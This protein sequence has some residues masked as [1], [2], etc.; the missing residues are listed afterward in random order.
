MTIAYRVLEQSDQGD[1][2]EL[3]SKAEREVQGKR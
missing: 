1:L 3:S 2:E